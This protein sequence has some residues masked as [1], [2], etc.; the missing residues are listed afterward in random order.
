M[1]LQVH[2]KKKQKSFERRFFRKLEKP[3]FRS[4]LVPLGLNTLKQDAYS[5]KNSLKSILRLDDSVTS[6]NQKISLSNFDEK[7]RQ[8]DKMGKKC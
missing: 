7:S 5:K 8:M 1:L 2:A 4:T 6:E 3:N